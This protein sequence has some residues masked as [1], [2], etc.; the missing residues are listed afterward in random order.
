[1]PGGINVAVF[2]PGFM[3]GTSLSRQHGPGVQR[4]GE[5]CS[6]YHVVQHEMPR[7]G[8]ACHSDAKIFVKIS[9]QDGTLQKPGYP[10]AISTK[11]L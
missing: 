2:E 4:M 7:L 1:V 5:G 6:D 11:R 9:T 10:G 3:P 8:R